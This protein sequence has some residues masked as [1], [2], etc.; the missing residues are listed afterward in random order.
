MSNAGSS[1]SGPDNIEQ[2]DGDGD[3]SGGALA[4]TTPELP[5]IDES[6]ILAFLA[7]HRPFGPL[8]KEAQGRVYR[9]LGDKLGMTTTAPA[10][11]TRVPRPKESDSGAAKDETREEEQGESE[12][13][14]PDRPL[15]P[16]GNDGQT[17]TVRDFMKAKKPK[18]L[19]ERVACLGYYLA[20]YR[21]QK[22]FM[23]AD[24]L[25]L[26]DDSADGKKIASLGATI[27]NATR[28]DQFITLI[29][30]GSRSLTVRGEAVVEALPD[31]EKVATALEEHSLAPRR[32]KKR[33][34]KGK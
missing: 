8:N 25:K 14:L 12:A 18:N 9:W 27:D 34:A 32:G 28:R 19:S 15:D 11:V 24:I 29:G 10:P 5:A 22:R 31:R 26:S 16:P 7:A 2:P 17:I 30:D 1:D 33:A 21:E 20:H 23:P 3:T 13:A 4:D 6:D